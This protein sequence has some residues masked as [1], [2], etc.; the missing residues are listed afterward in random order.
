MGGK[1]TPAETGKGVPQEDALTN[2]LFDIRMWTKNHL[3]KGSRMLA[4][5]NNLV[6]SVV[7]FESNVLF[8]S[9]TATWSVLKYFPT[10][11][12]RCRR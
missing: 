1:V 8:M 4:K 2:T 10:R 5:N 6:K 11:Y 9:L 3:A 7:Q 12:R